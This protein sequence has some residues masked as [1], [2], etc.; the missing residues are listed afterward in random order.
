M[1]IELSGLILEE[2]ALFSHPPSGGFFSFSR[3]RAALI[4]HPESGSPF[5]SNPIKTGSPAPSPTR[6][7][8]FPPPSPPQAPTPPTSQIPP[9]CLPHSQKYPKIPKP[10]PFR[11]QIRNQK[12]EVSIHPLRLLTFVPFVPF[13]VPSSFNIQHSTFIVHHSTPPP[14]CSP[15]FRRL[16]PF[17]PF[18]PFE[19]P[20]S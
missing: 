19:V 3:L 18:V 17:V 15:S 1:D 11:P 14:S 6:P 7:P 13:V 10:S 9:K 5:L 8:T 20:S 4:S 12:S 2:I 16:P